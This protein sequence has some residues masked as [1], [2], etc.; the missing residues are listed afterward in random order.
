MTI[1]LLLLAGFAAGGGV[2]SLLIYPD[3][4]ARTPSLAVRRQPAS[5]R[6]AGALSLAPSPSLSSAVALAGIGVAWLLYVRVR[7]LARKSLTG[8]MRRGVPVSSCRYGKFF[9][10]E[11]YYVLIVWPLKVAGLPVIGS[12]TTS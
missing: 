4:L 8:A 3:F 1:P 9:F 5:P 7:A 11:I 12:S 10:D 6:A 2:C